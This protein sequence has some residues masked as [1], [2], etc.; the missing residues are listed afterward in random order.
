MRAVLRCQRLRCAAPGRAR[1][2]AIATVF[3]T[4]KHLLPS[5]PE[6]AGRYGK[7]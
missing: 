5:I 7:P 2:G 4:E 3:G 1:S 6:D